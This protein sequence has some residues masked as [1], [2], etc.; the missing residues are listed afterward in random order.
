MAMKIITGYTGGKHITP[1][2]DAGFI[3]GILGGG[4]YVLDT[5]SKFEAT[6]YSANE[7]KIADGELVMQGRHARND[8]AYEIVQLNNG[9]YGMNR[10]DL[11]VARYTKGTDTVE[12]ISLVAIAGEEISGTATDP[13]YNK[14]DIDNGEARDFPLYRVK[15]VGGAIEAIEQ[16]WKTS[17]RTMAEMKDQIDDK[18][19]AGHGYGDEMMH[20]SSS[21]MSNNQIRYTW[22]NLVKDLDEKTTMQFQLEGRLEFSYSIEEEFFC[23]AWKY[24]K[25]VCIV[26]AVSE[27][28]LSARKKFYNGEWHEWEWINAP[29]N[30]DDYRTVKRY[31]NKPVYVKRV[32]LSDLPSNGK[33][34]WSLGDIQFTSILDFK[35]IVHRNDGIVSQLP[36]V[37]I[38]GNV[39]ASARLIASTGNPSDTSNNR[40]EFYSYAGFTGFNGEAYIEYTKRED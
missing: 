9:I 25:D 18:A 31:D 37:D 20:I 16:L 4:D 35:A 21:G 34:T 38:N 36:Y 12:T 30:Y 28:G 1:A 2:D 17:L 10:N 7:I 26:E 6:V 39:L 11:I 15:I 14:G 40:I 3:K 33:A 13:D 19:P 22:N 32:F 23:T 5:G 29:M 24:G 27:S 8:S